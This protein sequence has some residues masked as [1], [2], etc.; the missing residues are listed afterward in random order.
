L[1]EAINDPLKDES[2]G[3]IALFVVR[4]VRQR[5]NRGSGAIGVQPLENAIND[6]AENCGG[7]H[8]EFSKKAGALAPWAANGIREKFPLTY[9][10]TQRTFHFGTQQRG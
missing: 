2:F 3:R 1:C 8:V 5:L 4:K 6:A 10:I 9:I 7:I